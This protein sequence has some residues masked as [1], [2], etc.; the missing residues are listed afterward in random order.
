MSTPPSPL[1]PNLQRH[2]LRAGLTRREVSIQMDTTERTVAR[3]EAND[4]QPGYTSLLGLAILYDTTVPDF[5]EPRK[6]RAP[7]HPK[8]PAA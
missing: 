2:R 1:G 7:K 8:R 5:Y 3:W 6:N 4:A